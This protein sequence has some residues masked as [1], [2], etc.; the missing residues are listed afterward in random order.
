MRMSVEEFGSHVTSELEKWKA[1]A[2]KH[3]ITSTN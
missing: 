1:L 2:K 3:N